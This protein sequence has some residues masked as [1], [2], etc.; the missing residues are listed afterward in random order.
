M[1]TPEGAGPGEGASTGQSEWTCYRHP[2]R[3]SGVR[4]TRCERPICPDCMITAPV[5]FQCPE[6]VKGEPQVR[7]LRSL[8]SPPRL[9][10]AIIAVNVAVAVLALVTGAADG[11]QP[12]L[13]GGGNALARDYALTGSAV[14]AGEWWRLVT[15]GFLHYGLLHLGFNM[16]ILLQL[17]TLLEPAL[18][19]VRLAALY[20]AALLGGS[21]GVIVLQPDGL[22]AGASGAVFGL[23]GAAVI[24]MRSRGADPMASGLPMLLGINLLL[25]F[26]LPGIS[27]GAHLGGLAVG[28]AAGAV[29]FATDRKGGAQQAAGLAVVVAMAV[30][31][32]VA[33]IL[34]A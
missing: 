31:S 16:F 12:S 14:A 5:G 8:V 9:T 3:S 26:A 22:S 17:G 7:T 21:L 2:S 20:V 30:A 29:L 23:M 19:R 28:A 18:G 6:C 11:A 33:A 1:S 34:L 13:F 24:G 10:Q 4:C 32:F 27:I 25:T 15:S